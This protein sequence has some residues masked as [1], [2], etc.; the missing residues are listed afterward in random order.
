MPVHLTVEGPAKK[1]VEERE[2]A[3]RARAMLRLLQLE[4]SELSILLTGDRQIHKLNKIYRAKDRPTDVL[5][6]AMREGEFGDVAARLLGDVIISIP[7]AARQAK[8][9]QVSTLEETT[10]LLAHGL[11]HLLGWDH[12]T[13]KKDLAMR[14]E[15]ER[16]CAAAEPPRRAALS[17][18]KPAKRTTTA[19]APRAKG[20]TK[21][22]PRRRLT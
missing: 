8:E 18:S 11:L 10:M 22:S 13:K 15:T 5:A 17:R 9:R 4:K 6:F 1:T 21:P 3:R 12:D 20:S 19:R 16:L 14:A 7:T 2:I